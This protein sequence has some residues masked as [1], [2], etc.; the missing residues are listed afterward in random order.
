MK[1]TFTSRVSAAA[2]KNSI[3]SPRI[4]LSNAP[5]LKSSNVIMNTGVYSEPVVELGNIL[6][7]ESRIPIVLNKTMGGDIA[8]DVGILLETIS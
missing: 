5:P 8:L 1:K 6:G 3:I 2:L 4:G 7:A